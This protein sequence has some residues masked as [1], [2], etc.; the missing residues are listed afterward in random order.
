[1]TSHKDLV[2]HG[3]QHHRVFPRTPKP[4]NV[5]LDVD[6]TCDNCD[7]NFTKTN[8]TP[9]ASE[10]MKEHKINC[11]QTYQCD[12]CD[13][14]K[15]T[16]S[17]MK[18]HTESNHMESE[19]PEFKRSKVDFEEV[20]VE[21]MKALSVTEGNEL[22]QKDKLEELQEEEGLKEMDIDIEKKEKERGKC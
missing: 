21:N 13:T 15:K 11:K 3:A 6:E 4:T 8:D 17:E 14:K 5:K 16:K 10:I 1:M 20:A 9:R 19:S 18:L 22:A 7:I 12:Q 2:N